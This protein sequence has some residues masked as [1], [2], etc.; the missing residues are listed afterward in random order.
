LSADNAA[1]GFSSRVRSWL[2]YRAARAYDGTVSGLCA[3]NGERTVTVVIPAREEERTVG[4]IVKTIRTALMEEYPLVDD[5][6][7]VDSR[8]RDN[9]A[10]VAAEAGARVVAQDTV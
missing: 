2:R 8:S 1:L 5:V 6:L 10:R 3:L 9:T 7:V 4:R